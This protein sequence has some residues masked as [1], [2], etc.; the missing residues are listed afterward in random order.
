MKR[1]GS[2]NPIAFVVVI[3]SVSCFFVLILSIFRLPDVSFSNG[4]MT[5]FNPK[6]ITKIP[7]NDARIGK[8]GEIMIEMLP[9][10]LPFTIFVPSEIAFERDLK[11]RVNN[12]LAGE[13]ADDTYATLT[14][15]LSFT[16]V[17]WKILSESLSY[18]E[19]ITC[20]SLS[21]FKL[22]ISKDADKRVVVNSV[23]SSRVD[24]RIGEMVIHVMDGVLMEAEF[25][26][27]VRSDDGDEDED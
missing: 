9:Q 13:K 27:S 12:S 23:G 7:E 16:V 6:K 26:Q 15:I 11:L 2:K 24:L 19:E 22:H 4:S 17:P 20:D 8:F 10:D 25:E 3:V 14:R 1:G 18:S 21:G 5:S